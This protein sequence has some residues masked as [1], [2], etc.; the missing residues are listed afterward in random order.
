MLLSKYLSVGVVGKPAAVSDFSDVGAFHA[1][2]GF[3]TNADGPPTESDPTTRE[4]RLK[5][6]LAEIQEL[7]DAYG[8]DLEVH[9]HPRASQEV[10]LPHV[11][12]ELVD[13]AYVTLG[14]AHFHRLPWARVFRSVHRA[15]LRKA[16]G[17]SVDE[18][19]GVTKPP[20]WRPPDV[21]GI[22][23]AAGW[24]GPPLGL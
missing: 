15:N 24:P 10:Y 13:V 17:P 5:F 2:F 3:A 23:T 11:A 7:A 19:F 18:K 16:R 6:I 4:A 14:T 22:L 21:L 8:Y 9:L 20:G 1:H 12:R